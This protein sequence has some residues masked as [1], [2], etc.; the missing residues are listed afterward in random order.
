MYL[1][2]QKK[3]VRILVIELVRI[4]GLLYV[5][6]G[7]HVINYEEHKTKVRVDQQ[8][9]HLVQETWKAVFQ[10]D[11]SYERQKKYIKDINFRH[12]HTV[13]VS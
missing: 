2:W 11:I 5:Y 1:I 7:L 6:I 4:D 13:N 10:L 12:T 8:D 9:I 3:K